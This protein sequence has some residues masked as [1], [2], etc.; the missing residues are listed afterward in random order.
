MSDRRRLLAFGFTS[1][2]YWLPPERGS[3]KLRLGQPIAL[4]PTVYVFIEGGECRYVGRS[5]NGRD[6]LVGDYCGSRKK[7]QSQQVQLREAVLAG[8]KIEMLVYYPQPQPWNGLT[9]TNEAGIEDALIQEFKPPWNTQ[10]G[11]RRLVTADAAFPGAG[12]I[13]VD[14]AA[15][16]A[17]RRQ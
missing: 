9:V 15:A 3:D 7:W 10:N 2:G 12:P 8:R 6:R 17:G 14:A 13:L 1:V 11:K 16:L 4:G 5:G